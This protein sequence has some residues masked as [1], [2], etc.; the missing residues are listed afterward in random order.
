MRVFHIHPSLQ[1]SV[2]EVLVRSVR[3][4]GWRTFLPCLRGSA[5]RAALSLL[6][7]V[8]GFSPSLLSAQ[9][10]GEIQGRAVDLVSGNGVPGATVEIPALGRS[11]RTD[12]AGEFRIRGLDPGTYELT[13]AT[14]GY[15]EAVERVTVGNAEVAPVVFQLAP[16]ALGLEGIQVEGERRLDVGAHRIG[17]QAVEASGARS[18]DELLRELPGVTVQSRGPGSPATVSLRGSGDDAVLVLVDGVALNDPLTGVADLSSLSASAVEEITVIPG[19]RS[20]RYGPRAKGGVILVTT[21][22]ADR[23]VRS[24]LAGGSLGLLGTEVE[25]G[26]PAGRFELG[27]AAEWS[28]Q[29]GS[30]SFEKPPEVG[31]GAGVRDNADV[32]H[33]ALRLGLTGEAAGGELRGRLQVEELERGIPGKSFAPSPLARQD[34]ARTRAATAW[35]RSM[36]DGSLRLS[37]SGARQEVS[38]RDPTPPFGRPYDERTRLTYG[39][40]RAEGD[41]R[42]GWTTGSVRLGGGLDADHQR[43][44]ASAL[45]EAAPSARTD[46]G[47]RATSG[48]R[49]SAAPA[50]PELTATLRLHRDELLDASGFTHDLTLSASPGPLS[51][52]LAHRSGYSPPTLGDQ[53][54]REGVAVAPNPDLDAERVPNEWEL[55]L[56][57]AGS[58]R[59]LSFSGHAALFRGDVKGLIVWSPDF[60]FVWSPRNVDVKRSGA[61]AQATVRHRTTGLHLSGSYTLA[62]VT[63]DRED[64]TPVQVIYRPRHTGS[65]RAG[66]EPQTG[67][68]ASIGGRYLGTRYPVA[69]PLNA[70]PPFWNVDL[71]LRGRLALRD[72]LLEPSLQVDRILDAK[73]SFIFAFPEPGR[74]WTLQLRIRTPGERPGTSLSARTSS[75]RP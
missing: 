42:F 44:D 19:A 27:A 61:E 47:V 31:G 33:R 25:A 49:W 8:A 17:R 9:W 73:D 48:V 62:R 70:L 30:F 11:T 53:F 3:P 59:E 13:A 71:R 32:R 58:H 43:V 20:A 69:A 52:H 51:L 39:S 6:L 10:P 34:L 46:V 40:F 36:P 55:G 5:L 22:G 16:D 18:T 75:E 7:A 56:G 57:G 68:E 60:R 50:R 41:R 23:G 29:R 45:S 37:L 1:A 64:P 38:H 63:Y 74:T 65:A 14:I 67:W 2:Q 24:R 12:G 21:R 66:W 72:W 54:F 15:G 26:V 28:E 4:Y 35:T